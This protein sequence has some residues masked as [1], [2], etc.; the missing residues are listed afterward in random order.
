MLIYILV[1]LILGPVFLLVWLFFA[2]FFHLLE[3][4]L[5]DGMA[6]IYLDLKRRRATRRRKNQRDR[7][8]R[9]LYH[10]KKKK[11]HRALT[12]PSIT[13]SELRH[14]TKWILGFIAFITAVI[15]FFKFVCIPL[16]PWAP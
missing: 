13:A 6:L 5:K 16:E 1:A 3:N 7:E 14:Y 15:L 2:L 10:P 12:P 9:I 4:G 8:L 11:P